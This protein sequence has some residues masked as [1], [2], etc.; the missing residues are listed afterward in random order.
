MIY[1]ELTLLHAFKCQGKPLCWQRLSFAHSEMSITHAWCW[2]SNS[3]GAVVPVFKELMICWEITMLPDS[4]TLSLC[5]DS[6]G[7]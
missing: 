5:R 3:E 6:P 4:L 2:Q 7:V 1:Q